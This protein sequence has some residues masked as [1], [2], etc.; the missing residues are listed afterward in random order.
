MVRH[1]LPRLKSCWRRSHPSLFLGNLFLV[2]LKG[3][4]FSSVYS[5][6]YVPSVFQNI[7]SLARMF[8]RPDL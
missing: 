7:R 5:V 8:P 3:L 1:L 4:F 6:A 2:L